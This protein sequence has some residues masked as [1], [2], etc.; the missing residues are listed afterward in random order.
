MN[1]GQLDRRIE[2]KQIATAKDEWNYDVTTQSTLASVWAK[3]VERL[4]GEL[5]GESQLVSQNRVDW[6]IR[7]RTDLTASMTIVYDSNEYDIQGIKELGR[8]EGLLIH[9]ELRDNA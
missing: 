9:S 1:I 4:A 6:V 5:V 2:I 8:K 7:H 3:K